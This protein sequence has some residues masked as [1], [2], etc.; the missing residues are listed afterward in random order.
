MVRNE[1]DVSFKVAG[2]AL[3][4]GFDPA[5]LAPGLKGVALTGTL[6][7]DG[8]ITVDVRGVDSRL[9]VFL[10]HGKTDHERREHGR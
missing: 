8:G 1:S 10:T 6:R 9:G 4:E 2:Y 7:A 3:P 5:T